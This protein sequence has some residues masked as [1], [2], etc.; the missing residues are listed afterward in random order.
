MLVYISAGFYQERKMARDFHGIFAKIP[1]AD[2]PVRMPPILLAILK[3]GDRC[4]GEGRRVA[5]TARGIAGTPAP[6]TNIAAVTYNAHSAVPVVNTPDSHWNE[7]CFISCA[8]SGFFG[9]GTLSWVGD[10]LRGKGFRGIMGTNR[11]G[12]TNLHQ[13][14]EAAAEPARVAD[15]AAR[16]EFER[17]YRRDRQEA[18]RDKP[19]ARSGATAV[20]EKSDD[21]AHFRD[22]SVRAGKDGGEHD[23][24]LPDGERDGDGSL[25]SLM[26]SLFAERLGAS[27]VDAAHTASVPAGSAVPRSAEMVEHLVEQILVSHPDQVGDREVRLM[28]RNSVL[29]DTEI[30]LSRG[31]DGLLSVTLATGRNDAFQ[32]LVAAQVE[33]KQALDARENREVRLTVVDT[34]DAGAEEGGSDRRSRGHMDYYDDDGDA[35]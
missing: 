30:R 19:E 14:Q 34:R 1:G 33:L 15:E 3:S 7:T 9:S 4:P 29:P 22:M 13:T 26:H 25:A 32:T 6:V 2:F 12:D 20:A 5:D 18:S 23:H 24:P 17:L 10:I 16:R 28:V 21:A 35:R 27:S 31:T 11:I 8:G